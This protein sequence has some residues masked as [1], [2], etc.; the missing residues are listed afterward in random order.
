MRTGVLLAL[1]L[2]ACRPMEGTEV[3]YRL[4][5]DMM[6]A[7]VTL[8]T[9]DHE[10]SEELPLPLTRT[11]RAL[12]GSDLMVSAEGPATGARIT[13]EIEVAGRIVDQQTAPDGRNFTVC[14]A[15]AS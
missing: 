15:K 14:R 7:Q 3:V 4:S 1:M 8:R 11:V 9:G 2:A 13:C 5:G 10:I 6:T 12:S